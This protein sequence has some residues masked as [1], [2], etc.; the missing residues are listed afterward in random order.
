MSLRVEKGRSAQSNK[1]SQPIHMPGLHT[2]GVGGH[3]PL[4]ENINNL[5]AHNEGRVVQDVRELDIMLGDGNFLVVEDLQ[6]S[7]QPALERQGDV[8]HEPPVGDD[9]SHEGHKDEFGG[10]LQPGDPEV[11]EREEVDGVD[12][13][14]FE[15]VVGVGVI[16]LD[17]E[18]IKKSNSG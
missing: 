17:L 5:L 3:I 6:G 9:S 13:G 10:Q 1:V 15:E 18:I 12:E 8:V 4:R 16:V 11:G 2:R 7:Q 14:P